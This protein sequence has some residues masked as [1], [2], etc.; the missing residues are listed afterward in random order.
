MGKFEVWVSILGLLL[1]GLLNVNSI[2]SNW[3]LKV[4]STIIVPD[5]YS[6][7][8]EAINNAVEGDTIFVRAGIYYEHVTIDKSISLI[9]EN[10]YTTIVDGEGTGSVIRVI[11]DNVTIIGFTVQNSG[12]A[13]N[14]TV[15]DAGISTSHVSDCNVSGN[16][17]T[18]N[19]VG[20]FVR[21]SRKN[22]FTN[23]VITHNHI[24]IDINNQS[25]HNIISGNS[26]KENNVSI[27]IYYADSNVFFQNNLT[28]SPFGVASGHSSNNTFCRNEISNVLNGIKIS[29]ADFNNISQ[30]VMSQLEHGIQLKTDADHNFLSKNSITNCSYGIELLQADN[31]TISQNNI[32]D[33]SYAGIDLDE[34]ARDNNLTNNT[35]ANSEVGIDVSDWSANNTI[36]ANRLTANLVGMHFWYSNLNTICE[37]NITSNY[38]G[39]VVLYSQSNTFYH[40]TFLNNTKQVNTSDDY[41][42]FWNDGYPSGGNYW[43]DYNGTDYYSGIMQNIT[44]SDG[45]GDESYIIDDTTTDRY[46]LM[47]PWIPESLKT[48]LNNDGTVNIIDISIVAMAFGSTHEDTNWN[49]IADVNNDQVINILDISMVAKDYGKTA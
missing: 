31:N 27:H 37:N 47:E 13:I 34:H 29:Y 26:L 15:P 20:I 39:V 23:N 40:N 3:T 35:I 41:T 38:A 25:T 24:G 6:T 48:D 5:Q 36:S 19:H 32:T 42:N 44:G 49:I 7:I 2:R 46:P 11:S 17:L 18:D 16:L 12:R 14:N 45:I 9:G 22:R 10:K 33:C 30:N 8:H 4:P 21:P 1:A 43:S 28:D